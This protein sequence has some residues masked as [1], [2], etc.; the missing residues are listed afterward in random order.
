MKT[1]RTRTVDVDEGDV[2][3][4]LERTT[5]GFLW[6]DEVV[7]QQMVLKCHPK[8]LHKAMAAQLIRLHELHTAARGR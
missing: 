3:Q 5:W 7:W 6:R 4:I 1:Y 2:L 8:A